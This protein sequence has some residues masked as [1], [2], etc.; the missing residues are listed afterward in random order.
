MHPV[1]LSPLQGFEIICIILRWALPIAGI[2]RP[3]RAEYRFELLLTIDAS[4][5]TIYSERKDFTGFANAAFTACK[6]TVANAIV[7]AIKAATANIH[8]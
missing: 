6:L 1:R 7:I 2:C 3:F 4:R 8:H 5:L